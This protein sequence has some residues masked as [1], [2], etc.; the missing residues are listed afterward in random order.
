M[1]NW[2]V[3][4][5][6]EE[7]I[8]SLT[9][10]LKERFGTRLSYVGLQGSYLRGEANDDSDIDIMVVI[11]QLSVT[12]L[13]EYRSIIQ[14][15]DYYD[16]SCGF[17]CSKED[18]RNWNPLEICNLLHS[19]KDYYGRLCD[20]IPD[21]SEKDIENFVKVSVNNLYHEI[22][23]RYIYGDDNKNR[24][25]L[26]SAYKTVFFILQNLYYLQTHQFI[27]AK[28]ELLSLLEGKNHTV[29]EMSMIM[30]QGDAWEFDESFELLFSWCQETLKSI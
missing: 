13:M 29:L 20:L 14:S 1:V 6:I 18:L 12:D 2:S 28:R 11:D 5:N 9:L 27:A 24:S 21:Y 7:Y 10:I 23:H 25:N 26:P 22:C 17:I 15:M 4:I 16:K 19:T 3:M 30:N 8:C